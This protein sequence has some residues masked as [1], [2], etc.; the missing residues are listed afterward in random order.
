MAPQK[1]EPKKTVTVAFGNTI[2]IPGDERSQQA[3]VNYIF[4]IIKNKDVARGIAKKITHLSNHPNEIK[5]FMTQ[6]VH[7]HALPPGADTKI[8]YGRYRVFLAFEYADVF[9]SF[10]CPS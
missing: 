4:E 10:S 2:L 3:L 1:T 7:E 5:A 9:P 6:F 8:E